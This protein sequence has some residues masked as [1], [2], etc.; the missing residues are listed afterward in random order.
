MN[1]RTVNNPYDN[2]HT[3]LVDKLIGTAYDVVRYVAFNME[4][5]IYVADNMEAIHTAATG[6]AIPQPLEIINYTT[7]TYALVPR[8]A[9]CFKH[10]RL[11]NT[12]S[13]NC[14]DPLGVIPI[15]SWYQFKNTGTGGVVLIGSMFN[16]PDSTA[17]QIR[18]KGEARL[19]K[20][21]TNVWDV[22]GDMV[23]A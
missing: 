22:V 8:V 21:G 13:I 15:G 17:P 4:K 12:L 1:M 6:Q 19:L 9:D 23:I 10:V 16:L 20:V 11:A 5:L 2:H 3:T 18:A 14:S 7:G